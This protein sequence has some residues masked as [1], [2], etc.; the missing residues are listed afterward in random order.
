VKDELKLERTYDASPEEVFDAWTNPAVLKR[1]WA[2]GPDWTAPLIEVDLRVGGRYRLA[3][4]NPANGRVHTVAGEY[5][6]IDRPN[7]LTYS[8]GWEN[9]PRSDHVSTVTVEFL[10]KDGQTTVVLTHSDLESDES[11]GIHAYGW[12]EVMKT[13]EREVF[14]ARDR[15]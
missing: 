1:W 8:W 3:T 14:S 12:A 13:L 10:A 9:E 4:R 5:V 11:Y 7:L 2:P 6:E 15:A